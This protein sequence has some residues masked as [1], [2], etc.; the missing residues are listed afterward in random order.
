MLA[1]CMKLRW[2][3]AAAALVLAACGGGGGYGGGST[4]STTSTTDTTGMTTTTV[5]GTTTT[6]V[7]GTT[8]AAVG[9]F[10]VTKL[11]A[12]SA[13]AGAAHVDANLVDAWGVAF[14][15]AAFVWVNNAGTETS[16]LYDGDGVPQSLVVTVPAGAAGS[17]SPTGIV[18]NGSPS[19]QV[20]QGGLRGAPFFIF[21]SERGTI[22]G[23][24]P[25][26]NA[27]R[28]V[29]MVDDG[30]AG[31]V[32]TGL[33]IGS[34]LLYAADFRR[35]AVA[36]FD[37][38]FAR[39]TVAGGFSDP[40]LPAGYSPYGIHAIGDLVYVAY[41]RA[42]TSGRSPVVGAGLGIVDAFSATGTLVRRVVS[43]GG[44]LN[45]PWGLS[46]APATFG[47]FGNALLVANHGD[48]RIG[49]F[50]AATGAPLG[51]LSAAD[52]SAIAID[53]LRGIA[54]GN[55]RNSQPSTTLF[56]AAGPG[57]GVHGLYGRIDS[58]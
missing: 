47:P 3:A 18:F 21:A 37:T 19:F 25:S 48:G 10:A 41:A 22:S 2:L 29:T 15:P 44:A 40:A 53:G 30:A 54:F 16:T 34:G 32:Y 39:T 33:A 23:W 7:T 55:D 38:N 49:A 11:V 20:T 17:A 57:G 5:T 43:E 56:F 8:T 27:T 28:A 35:G 31:A 13:A 14:N 26:V 9:A 51:T 50:D 1:H 24:S 6:T 36:V 45:A 58:Q 42:D 46:M 4:A 12:D 52:G